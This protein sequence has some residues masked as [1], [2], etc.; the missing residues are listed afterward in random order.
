MA[1]WAVHLSGYQ[2]G[3]TYR[4]EMVREPFHFGRGGGW[5]ISGIVTQINNYSGDWVNDFRTY[6]KLGTSPGVKEE[7]EV[8]RHEASLEDVRREKER[9]ELEKKRKKEAAERRAKEEV[10]A[11]A[12]LVAIVSAAE[13]QERLR[14]QGGDW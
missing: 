9:E 7:R 10:E 2:I 14:Q 12:Q 3:R 4:P 13:T 8:L 6:L 1:A 11:E 5:A